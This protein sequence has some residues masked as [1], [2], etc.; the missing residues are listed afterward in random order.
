M[1][2]FFRACISLVFRRLFFACGEVPEDEPTTP[3]N[4]AV[5][6]RP[7]RASGQRFLFASN[8]Y[9]DAVYRINLD[10]MDVDEVRVGNKPRD[11][12]VSPDG[13]TVAVVNEENGSISVIDTV[14]LANRGVR[15]GYRPRDVVFSPDGTLLATANYDESSV[16]VIDLADLTQWKV[17]VGGGPTSLSFD[18]ESRYL[19]VANYSTD[20]FEVIDLETKQTLLGWLRAV[21]HLWADDPYTTTT[22]F[23]WPLFWPFCWYA[24]DTHVDGLWDLLD[25][26]QV[27]SFGVAGTP[28]ERMLVLGTRVDPFD[29]IDSTTEFSV[30]AMTWPEGMTFGEFAQAVEDY[31]EDEIDD[32]DTADDDTVDIGDDLAVYGQ[33]V[34]TAINPGAFVWNRTGTALYTINFGKDD[35]ISVSTVCRLSLNEDGVMKEEGRAAV[36]LHPVALAIS[37]DDTLVATAN[38]DENTVTIVRADGWST[39]TV[40]TEARPFALAFNGSGTKLIVVHETPLMPVSVVDV[41]SGSSKVVIDSLSMSRWMD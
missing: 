7:S 8:P 26:P 13:N 9:M 37:D 30:L 14:S 20:D 1:K 2:V 31:V 29:E 17:S 34:A 19:A 27:I 10:N 40:T 39:K 41:A 16:S 35:A 11:I 21:L 4:T 38:K 24:V 18:T 25:R 22:V 33:F 32:D 15:V 12:A 6:A 5:V 36:G 23:C 28:S 3:P